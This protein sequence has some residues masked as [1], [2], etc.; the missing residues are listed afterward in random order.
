MSFIKEDFSLYNDL[1]KIGQSASPSNL[2]VDPAKNVQILASLLNTLQENLATYAP[3]EPT[4]NFSGK[5]GSQIFLFDLENEDRFLDFLFRNKVTYAGSR[6]VYSHAPVGQSLDSAKKQYDLDVEFL[7]EVPQNQRNQYVKYPRPTDAVKD[8]FKYWIH[9]KYVIEFL[10][11]LLNNANEKN[12][13]LQK[14]MLNKIIGNLNKNSGE[15]FN[16]EEIPPSERTGKPQALDTFNKKINLSNPTETG[17]VQLLDTDVKSPSSLNDWLR[18]NQITLL[19]PDGE[20]PPLDQENICLFLSYVYRRAKNLQN[21]GEANTKNLANYY[22]KQ[23]ESISSNY[24]CSLGAKPVGKGEEKPE[25]REKKDKDSAGKRERKPAEGYQGMDFSQIAT[26]LPL[27]VH[28][29][30]FN[31]ILRFFEICRQYLPTDKSGPILRINTQVAPLMN[32]AISMVIPQLGMDLDSFV[33]DLNASPNDV[34]RMLAVPNKQD[35]KFSPRNYIPFIETLVRIVNAASNA[36]IL[37]L[38]DFEEYMKANKAVHYAIRN[39]VGWSAGGSSV[40]ALNKSELSR[41][42]SQHSNIVK[43]QRG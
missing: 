28:N 29:I 8:N 4:G 20:L 42:L 41:L 38:R 23:V 32:E 9:K 35:D 18:K 40:A 6:L 33:F 34:L 36:V 30:D 15:N 21:F 12:N 14:V 24:S 31:K 19:S 22:V 11:T 5:E 43:F 7:T 2:T 39:Q 27:N 1:L 3:P 17:P 16:P 25:D 13:Q 26:N 10:N 37:L